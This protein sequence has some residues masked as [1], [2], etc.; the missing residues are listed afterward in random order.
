M[1]NLLSPQAEVLLVQAAGEASAWQKL[2]V[3]DKRSQHR[4]P[5]IICPSSVRPNF[6]YHCDSEATA[7]FRHTSVWCKKHLQ[8]VGGR[9]WYDLN[10]I[11][12]AARNHYYKQFYSIAHLNSN[13]WRPR[14]SERSATTKVPTDDH[15]NLNETNNFKE[16]FTIGIALYL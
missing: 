14:I 9:P 5:C 8:R 7:P 3:E 13:T 10:E 15:C 11:R 4:K 1:L 12:C 2:P 6:R 16:F